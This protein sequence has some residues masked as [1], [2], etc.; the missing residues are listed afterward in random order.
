MRTKIQNNSDTAKN[1][2]NKSFRITLIL[3]KNATSLGD[4]ELRYRIKHLIILHIIASFTGTLDIFSIPNQVLT[5][6]AL[7]KEFMTTL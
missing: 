6:Y 1:Y 5:T 4:S 7:G 2:R 3:L